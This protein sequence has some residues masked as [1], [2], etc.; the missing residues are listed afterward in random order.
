MPNTPPSSWRHGMLVGLV[1][2]TLLAGCREADRATLDDVAEVRPF[3]GVELRVLIVDDADLAEAIRQS[4][5]EWQARTDGG[6]VVTEATSAELLDRPALNAD[7]VVYPDAMLPELVERGWLMPLDESVVVDPQMK[8]ADVFEMLQLRETR[9]G[10]TTYAAPLGS[11][12]LVCLYRRDLFEQAGRQPPATWAEF[13]ELSA[14]FADRKHWPESLR[15]DTAV[16]S[17]EPTAD[18]WAGVTLLARAAGYA[19]HRDQYST[20]F[21]I[22][23]GE[24]L[25]DTPP[26]VR[27]L[28]ELTTVA[29][30]RGS[31]AA[32]TPPQAFAALFE[33]NVAMAITWPTSAEACGPSPRRQTTLRRLDHSPD[34]DLPVDDSPVDEL[35]GNSGPLDVGVAPLPGSTVV[36]HHPS[37]AWQDRRDDEDTS[38]TVLGVSGRLVSIAGD[39]P[40]PAAAAQL[41]TTLCGPDQ[42]TTLAITS[43]W[44]TLSRVSQTLEPEP[45]AGGPVAVDLPA[46]Y[47]A[48]LEQRLTTS[49]FCFAVRLPQRREYL[50]ALGSAV[51]MAIDGTQTPA[52]ALSAAAD[53]WRTIAEQHDGQSLEPLLRRN[54]GLGD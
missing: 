7:V 54:L 38:V 41:V 49:P 26:V 31:T 10:P 18:Q 36:Y 2:L 6:Y 9:W 21:D 43:P 8:W 33:G 17:L 42:V 45:W 19:K 34:D 11:P 52:E 27:A 23:S 22:A 53:A 16:G 5:G 25:I 44:C 32:L 48:H 37:S 14:Y 51:Q 47:G 20:F 3:A 13:D 24:P 15:P 46:D 12:L 35:K 39:T 40:H 4:Q 30:T 50:V 29:R 1:C 28:E